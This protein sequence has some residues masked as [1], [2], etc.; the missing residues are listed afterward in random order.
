MLSCLLIS[1][2]AA[3]ICSA[4]SVSRCPHP[5]TLRPAGLSSAH[6]FPWTLFCCVCFDWQ[7]HCR[8]TACY[9]GHALSSGSH[10]ARAASAASCVPRFALPPRTRPCASITGTARVCLLLPNWSVTAHS[11]H[12]RCL[13]LTNSSLA[14]LLLSGVELCASRLSRFATPRSSRLRVCHPYSAQ[15]TYFWLELPPPSLHRVSCPSAALQQQCSKPLCPS[16]RTL[17]H[18]APRT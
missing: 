12:G 14:S 4:L 3:T 13:C 1:N 7:C 16:I 18:A 2:T 15:P 17:L 6:L 5:T 10:G 9:G 8:Q 11:L